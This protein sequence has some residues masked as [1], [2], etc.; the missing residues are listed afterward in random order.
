MDAS[1]VH[2]L[3]IG[4][5]HMP[6]EVHWTFLI[7]VSSRLQGVRRF[8]P[9]CGI[10]TKLDEGLPVPN[11][12]R[13]KNPAHP[14]R[15]RLANLSEDESIE[16]F[17]VG[18]VGS[19]DRLLKILQED[20]GESPSDCYQWVRNTIN[21]LREDDSCNKDLREKAVHVSEEKW[22]E[23]NELL[24][25]D[26]NIHHNAR[27]QDSVGLGVEHQDC[28]SQ[29]GMSQHITHQSCMGSDGISIED[30][31]IDE[32]SSRIANQN[33]TVPDKISLDGLTP[34]FI[35]HYSLDKH[36]MVRNAESHHGIHHDGTNLGLNC[37]NTVRYRAINQ[38]IPPQNNIAC[39]T[40]LRYN[41]N[42]SHMGDRMV[43]IN[44]MGQ[45][46]DNQ[47]HKKHKGKKHGS[48][49]CCFSGAEDIN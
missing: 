5:Y 37:Q 42:Q 8:H 49:W 34:D 25:Q 9:C 22:F 28:T 44:N 33:V 40:T 13:Y 17:A 31:D 19:M 21:R 29:N 30:I 27:N 15:E 46:S 36:P 11:D 3:F 45:S 1:D 14:I 47:N 20:P 4:I 12:A 39:N 2:L 26:P 23:I 6:T 10:E 24:K 35:Q 16:K 43:S 7:E 38:N 48:K 32:I 41:A 18:K